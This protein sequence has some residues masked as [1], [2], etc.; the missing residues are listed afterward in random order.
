MAEKTTPCLKTATA[1]PILNCVDGLYTG[2]FCNE[3]NKAVVGAKKAG[4]RTSSIVGGVLGAFLAISIIIC[5]FLIRKVRKQSSLD[6]NE[7]YARQRQRGLVSQMRNLARRVPDRDEDVEV[8]N[9]G[10]RANREPSES[11]DFRREPEDS[12]SIPRPHVGRP[13][14]R[15][16]GGRPLPERRDSG[17]YKR[18]FSDDDRMYS[19]APSSRRSDEESRPNQKS[20]E[21]ELPM[22]RPL[23]KSSDHLDSDGR[24]GRMNMVQYRNRGYEEE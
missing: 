10:R 7:E 9:P 15:T 23:S 13:S 18:G 4:K 17:G 8:R 14:D 24:N 22:R 12:L 19:K 16:S 1:A 5:I 2:R 3:T 20:E 21:R 11:V 6:D